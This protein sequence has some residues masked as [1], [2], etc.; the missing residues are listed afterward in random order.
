MLSTVVL[1]IGP[2]RMAERTMS[3]QLR[4]ATMSLVMG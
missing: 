2:C 3:V 1:I 4:M